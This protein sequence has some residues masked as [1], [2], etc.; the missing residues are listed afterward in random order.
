MVRRIIGV[1]RSCRDHRPK[2]DEHD[3]GGEPALTALARKA[4]ARM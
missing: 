2:G 4:L 3:G 1:A